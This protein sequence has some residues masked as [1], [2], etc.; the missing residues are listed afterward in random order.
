M[1]YII[2][3]KCVLSVSLLIDS[4]SVD[5]SPIFIS[6]IFHLILLSIIRWFGRHFLR[7]W[8]HIRASPT[9]FTN[10]CPS[11]VS[12][13]TNRRY[14]LLFVAMWVD[15]IVRRVVLH[16]ALEVSWH[17]ANWDGRAVCVANACN[18]D[19]SWWVQCCQHSILLSVRWGQ[20]MLCRDFLF[21][22]AFLDEVLIS[23]VGKGDDTSSEPVWMILRLQLHFLLLVHLDGMQAILVEMRWLVRNLLL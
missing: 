18:V 8:G 10:F 23:R 11:K 1:A 17:H 22:N 9:G 2:A 15:R 13:L 19:G 14:H 4:L 20:G 16:S 12:R 7:I 21:Y 6:K 5:S 3:V